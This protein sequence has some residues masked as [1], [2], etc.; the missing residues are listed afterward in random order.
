MSFNAS[1]YIKPVDSTF[2]TDRELQGDQTDLKIND[3]RRDTITCIN[4]LA[5]TPPSGSITVNSIDP[6]PTTV[7]AVKD[8]TPPVVYGTVGQRVVATALGTMVLYNCSFDGTVFTVDD[9]M[10]S[11]FGFLVGPVGI[12]WFSVTDGQSQGAPL[13]TSVASGDIVLSNLPSTNTGVVVYGSLYQQNAT[14][15]VPIKTVI[16]YGKQISSLTP[17]FT[18]TI[19]SNTNIDPLSVVMTDIA[20]AAVEVSALPVIAGDAYIRF[21]VTVSQT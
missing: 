10:L 17:T 13:S 20:T 4:A 6:A 5:G 7:S 18:I 19:L 21:Y 8:L 16:D 9:T 3:L 14:L 15:G 11:A 2:A 12:S 1:D